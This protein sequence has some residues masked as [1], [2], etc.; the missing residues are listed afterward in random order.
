MAT[1]DLYSD[2]FAEGARLGRS[3]MLLA[4]N[5]ATGNTYNLFRVPRNAF[6]TKVVFRVITGFGASS[7][8]TIG[9]VGNGEVA[10]ADYFFDNT[11]AAPNTTGMKTSTVPKYF[12]SG[13]GVVTLTAGGTLGATLKGMLFIEYYL[14]Y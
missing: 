14:L 6:I 11:A 12:S 3:K 8:I 7:D 5:I 2:A 9:F 4:A 13:S 1:V 10:D